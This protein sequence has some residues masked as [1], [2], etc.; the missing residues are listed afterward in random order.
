MRER[1]N[2]D[3]DWLFHAGEEPAA[4]SSNFDDSAWRQL[5][6]PHDWSIEQTPDPESPTGAGVFT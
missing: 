3:K 5:D 1:K 4:Y 6:L 2:I